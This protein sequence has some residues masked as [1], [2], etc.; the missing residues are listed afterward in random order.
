MRTRSLFTIPV[1]VVLSFSLVFSGCA[2]SPA[3][4]DPGQT[5][6]PEPAPEEVIPQSP[7]ES[8]TSG[9]ST[10][11]TEVSPGGTSNESGQDMEGSAA[12]NGDKTNFRL[13][14]SDEVNAIAD[15][16]SLHVTI[17]SIGIHQ[18]GESGT[19]HNFDLDSGEDYDGDEV[20]GLDL[21]GITDVNALEI[22]SGELTEGEYTKVFIYVNSVTGELK[23]DTS[24]DIKL[25]S[26]KL[27]ISKPFNISDSVVEFV[28]DITVIKAGHSGMYVLKPQIAESGPN[29]PFNDVTPPKGKPEEEELTLQLASCDTGE[30]IDG[31]VSF[32]DEVKVLVTHEGEP[33][34]GA[35]VSIDGMDPMTT[36]EN[37]L[38]TCFAIPDVEEI[39]IGA[40]RDDLE[41]ELEIGQEN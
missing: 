12:T 27:H 17:S 23:D 33:M 6:S 29:Q 34:E 21:T 36:E 32:G 1:I 18:G 20:P 13:L 22:W 15:F 35:T 14:I 7:D 40:E 10:Q 5:T 11:E 24:P 19:W 2:A 25:P 41:G 38:T 39:E 9:E 26:D 28:Y 31:D 16:E 3:E 30:V 4:P 37:G 8:D